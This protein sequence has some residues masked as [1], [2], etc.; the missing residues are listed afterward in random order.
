M[1]CYQGLI[2][3][4]LEGDKSVPINPQFALVFNSRKHVLEFPGFPMLMK[5]VAEIFESGNLAEYRVID[6]ISS[7]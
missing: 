7:L 5:E 4:S 6:F 1:E 3:S 2:T